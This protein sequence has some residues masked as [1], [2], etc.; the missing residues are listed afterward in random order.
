[1]LNVNLAGADWRIWDLHAEGFAVRRIA[2]MTGATDDKVRSVV[3]GVWHDEKL[4]AR[5]AKRKSAA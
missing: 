5:E 3:T 2:A 1:M 4:A